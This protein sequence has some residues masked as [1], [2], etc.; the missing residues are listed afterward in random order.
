MSYVPDRNF[1]FDEFRPGRCK[2]L[3]LLTY[4]PDRDRL[5]VLKKASRN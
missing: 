3:G 2:E 4:D 5:V 1:L